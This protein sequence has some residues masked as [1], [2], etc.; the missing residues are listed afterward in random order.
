MFHCMSD[1]WMCAA[2]LHCEISRLVVLKLFKI[3]KSFSHFTLIL[4]F[5]LSMSCTVLYFISERAPCVSRAL[6]QPKK[7]LFHST[8]LIS[9]SQQSTENC[10]QKQI[11]IIIVILVLHIWRSRIEKKLYH[12]SVSYHYCLSVALSCGGSASENQTYLIQSSVTTLTSPCKYTICPV[13]TDIC[14]IRFDFTVRNLKR[15][16]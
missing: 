5:D 13:A 4:L 11:Y 6:K 3:F 16:R 12:M 2:A 14:R 1:Q 8:T 15:A 9:E 7:C 10:E